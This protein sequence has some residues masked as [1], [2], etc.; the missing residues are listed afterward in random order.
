MLSI[1]HFRITRVHH[2]YLAHIGIG[3]GESDIFL[4]LRSNRDTSDSGISLTRLHRG[5]DGIKLHIENLHIHTQ[6]IADGIRHIHIDAHNLTILVILER[7]EG[8]IGGEAKA[9]LQTQLLQGFRSHLLR[10]RRV[11]GIRR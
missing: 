4:S 10:I 11:R 7:F 1:S 5:D 3:I 8:G 6:H 2:D 9:L